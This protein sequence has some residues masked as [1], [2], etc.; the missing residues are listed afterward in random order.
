M[1]IEELGKC[2]NIPEFAETVD[3][4]EW[5]KTL[6]KLGVL[7]VNLGRLCNLRCRHCHLEA[8]PER[9]E[10]MSM[11]VMQ[12]C[13]SAA[14]KYGFETIDITGGAPEMF[15][16]FEF[17]VSESAK[18]AK[19][20]IVRS[21]LVILLG[22]KYRHLP[23]FYK[24][25]KVNIVCSLPFYTERN[26]DIQRGDR[27]FEKSLKVLKL[28]NEI[29]YG[30]DENLKLDIVYN[31]AGAFMPPCQEAMKKLYKERLGKEHGIVFNDLY[32]ITNNPIGRFGDF[33]KESGNLES[34]LEALYLNYNEAAVENMMC[35]N[36]ISVSWEGYIYDC[37]FNQAADIKAE[38]RLS[39]F[40]I[41]NEEMKPRTII[42]G[43]H[44]YACTAGAGSSCGGT[45]A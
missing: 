43:K 2:V 10:I 26:T 41:L 19:H 22:E 7:Q 8:G 1:N 36:Q 31:P 23:E 33:L 6:N 4:K 17:F 35:R 18:L 3:H 24:K 21:N 40:D 30:R 32:T 44:C 37:D 45:T 5:L 12:A 25:H 13:L 27:V 42:T 34:Y 28:L 15:P 39:I 11:E 9:K 38:G 16:N 29:G 14:K 20:V